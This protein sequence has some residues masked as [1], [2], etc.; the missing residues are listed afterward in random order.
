[1][2]GKV[3]ISKSEY[4]EYQMMKEDNFTSIEEIKNGLSELKEMFL[5]FQGFKILSAN[6]ELNLLEAENSGIADKNEI[7]KILYN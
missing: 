6:E 3:I 4:E 1:M 2:T 7:E 5:N